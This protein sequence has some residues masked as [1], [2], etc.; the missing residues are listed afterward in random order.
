M[1]SP[2]YDRLKAIFTEARDMTGAARRA[3]L[4][5]ACGD[6]LE[7]SG[8]TAAPTVLLDGLTVASG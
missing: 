5:D 4:D 1:T 8:A 7:W 6:D 2:R 3:C